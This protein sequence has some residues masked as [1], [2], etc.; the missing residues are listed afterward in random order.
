MV[1]ELPEKKRERIKQIVNLRLNQKI[2]IRE[3]AK[4]LG[5]LVSCCPAV[6]YG[7]VYTKACERAKYL[8]LNLAQ[9]DYNPEMVIS[10]IIVDDLKWWK[11][12][13]KVPNNPIRTAIYDLEISTDASLSGWGAFCNGQRAHGHW[14]EYE[15]CYSINHLE[16]MA[17]FYGLKIFGKNCKNCQ[18]LLHIDNM[19]AI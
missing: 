14:K 7:F 2:K 16:L 8:A 15:R 12:I 13:K 9:Y 4:I 18:I 10:K 11:A 19:T 3:F 6:S 1:V 17:A 5:I